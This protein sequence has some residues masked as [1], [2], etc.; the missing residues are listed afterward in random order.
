MKGS[1]QNTLFL[2]IFILVILVILYFV[3][4]FIVKQQKKETFIGYFQ[5]YYRPYTR[6]LKQNYNIITD[7]YGLNTVLNKMR[8]WFYIY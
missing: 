8:K 7:N 3:F 2:L 6:I 1:K 5:S 4:S